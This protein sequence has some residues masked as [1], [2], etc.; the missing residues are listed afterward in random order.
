MLSADAQKVSEGYITL[1]W[2]N[3]DSAQPVTLQ[4]G[5]DPQLLQLERSIY[6]QGQ[7]QAHLSGFSNGE[8]YARLVG[9]DGLVLSNSVHFQVQH[10]DLGTAT[11]LFCLGAVLFVFLVVSLMRF[12]HSTQ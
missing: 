5:V 9:T 3:L 6:L 11:L 2:N 12:T 7:N 1:S 4:V 8:Y 10:R